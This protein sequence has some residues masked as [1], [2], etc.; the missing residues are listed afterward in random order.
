MTMHPDFERIRGLHDGSL[1]AADR[2]PVAAHVEGCADCRAVLASIPRVVAQ[3]EQ[4]T[5]L[6]V[7]VG[8]WARILERRAAGERIIPPALALRT[9]DSADER[10]E[11][12][13]QSAPS[14]PAAPPPPATV[15]AAAAS[16]SRAARRAQRA[17]GSWPGLRR[18]A[19]L[20][21]ALA[22]VASATLAMPLILDRLSRDAAEREAP[23][24]SAPPRSTETV[25]AAPPPVTGV[26]ILPVDGAA[27]V[28]VDAPDPALRIRVRLVDAAELEVR[29][30][31]QGA[32]G[33]VF[34]PRPGALRVRDAGPGELELLLPRGVPRITVRV[35]GEPYLVKEG[36]QIRVLG[37]AADSA[38][39][40]VV[41]RVRRAP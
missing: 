21:L 35:D 20:V 38:D 9:P 6:D 32:V 39:S 8:A 10:V 23:P 28:D 30:V 41:L 12:P 7:P 13:V 40:E 36:G 26:S 5:D 2:A 19:A 3:V 22:G 31:G 29:A 16:A 27:A 24:A 1:A 14:A 4:A 33:A 34:Q 11:V 37:P 17:P 18:A 15:P 25:P